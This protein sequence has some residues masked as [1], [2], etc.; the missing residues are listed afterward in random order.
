MGKKRFIQ[1]MFTVLLVLVLGIAPMNLTPSVQAAPTA[2]EAEASGNLL[3]GGAVAGTCASCSGGSK[4]GYLG[5]GGTLQFNNIAGGTGGTASLTI[6][7]TAGDATRAATLNVN[8]SDVTTV[9][10]PSSGGWSTVGSHSVTISLNSGS[11]NT[12]KFYRN[13]GY[14]PDID[15]I[16]VNTASGTSTSY[17][18]NQTS[19]VD[20]S[21]ET[22]VTNGTVKVIYNK[23][24]GLADYY[25]N[26]VK[27]MSNV[28]SEFA[29]SATYK[30]KNYSTHTFST[31]DVAT[32]TDSFGT[33]T[34]ITFVNQSSGQPALRQNF[35][36][37]DG[38]PY[39]FTDLNAT[40]SAQ[41]TSNYMAPIK[42]DA[43]AV[44]LNGSQNKRVLLVPFD[45]DRFRR[46]NATS[47]NGS[48]NSYEVT[49]VYDNDSRN[50]VILGSITHE[51]WKTG[52]WYNG[53]NNNVNE[54]Q[55]Y[56]GAAD[57]NTSDL[58]PHG[59][60]TG[61]SIW[62]PKISVGYYSDWRDGMEEFGRINA[63]QNGTM[64]W[65]G[66]VPF[67]WNSWGTVQ[68]GLNYNNAVFH[69]NW[70]KNNL[71]NNSFNSNN[72]VYINLDSYWDNL[73]E[74]QLTDFVNTVKNNGQKAGIYWAPFVYW[75]DNTSQSVEGSNYVY[76]DIMLKK[77][78]GSYF[79]NSVD[80]AHP[81]DP[82]HP[83][84]KQRMNYY[85]DKFKSY[86]FEFIKLD[87]LSHG[88]FEGLHY[89]NNVKT[90]IQ[91]Y[92]QG[93][94]YVRDRIGGTMFI[95]ES[96]A[97]IFPSQ[98]AHARRISCDAFASVADSE[99]VLNSVAYGWWQNGTI[100]KYTDPDHMK[101][102]S[103]L[104]EARTRVNSAVIAG[105]VFLNG[106]DLQ[107]SNQ[108]NMALSLL[109]NANVN[110]VARKGKAFR[111]I[112]G[113]TG[114]SAADS[115]VLNDGGIYYLA[116]FNYNTGSSKSMSINLGRAGL[117][118]STSYTVTN[119][120]DNSSSTAS[121]TLN[122]TLGPSQSKLLKLN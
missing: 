41:L 72:T 57:G 6:Y 117:S 59:S 58:Q 33:G 23:T 96:I 63:L 69:S 68:T 17:Q 52:I 110:A 9:Q 48:G 53:A 104:E 99:Y 102:S 118:G 83:G 12:I 36:F 108:Q 115:F 64:S 67:G 8:G 92:N 25:F 103:N 55:V 10:F 43:Q 60:I 79:G 94:A 40:N 114:T 24:S 31:S 82:T 74:Q 91:A 19:V 87:F 73:T 116:L 27:R 51:T 45:N 18:Y 121:G 16:E 113:N 46:F 76:G 22:T 75:G 101:L 34:R 109:T 4:V 89:D 38:K 1:W 93:M 66:G 61:T 3:T 80:G 29:S 37:Y 112:E 122:V 106:N 85:I 15:K 78:D 77:Y 7:Y 35:Y 2:Y 5:N 97:P 90:G 21:S 20:S 14:A 49:A 30:S 88:S 70:I 71:Q 28:Y 95:S 26:N 65:N 100:Y 84:A 105:T 44:I 86:G 11:S 47:V 98:Y 32:F 50:G 56:G 13:G 119:L 54:L 107:D 39:F 120:W 42:S 62:S 111:L 81:V